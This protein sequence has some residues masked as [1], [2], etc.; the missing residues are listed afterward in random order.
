VTAATVWDLIDQPFASGSPA[1]K[2]GH[3]GGRCG[4]INEGK[5]LKRVALGKIDRPVFCGLY[6]LS[7]TVAGCAAVTTERV[8]C[9]CEGAIRAATAAPDPPL[10]PPG[11][12][13]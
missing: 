7:P 5:P 3:L 4:F 8:L 10:L 1:T 6:H 9:N 12:R 2:A 13:F 11:T